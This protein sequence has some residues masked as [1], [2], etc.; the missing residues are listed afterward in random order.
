VNGAFIRKVDIPGPLSTWGVFSI[1]GGFDFVAM[2][3][4]TNRLLTFEVMYP[5][6]Q[7]TLVGC[8]NALSIDYS[9]ESRAFVLVKTTGKL[10][11]VP[12]SVPDKRRSTC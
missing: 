6:K 3:T 10:K 11:I 2:I 7:F 9:M 1:S 8:K 4:P 12:S 5:E